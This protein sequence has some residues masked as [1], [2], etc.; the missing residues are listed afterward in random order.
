[1]SAMPAAAWTPTEMGHREQVPQE[2]H[3]AADRTSL[4]L[5]HLTEAG[6]VQFLGELH[7]A[8]TLNGEANTA[9]HDVWERWWRTLGLLHRPGFMKAMRREYETPD[10]G[11]RV[12]Q[13]P[14][15]LRAEVER[16]A[17]E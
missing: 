7:A 13:T 1:M 2:V 4:L 14:A 16:L 6:R 10:D 12:Y 3:E 8:A 5:A 11:V 17:A 9:V 15:E